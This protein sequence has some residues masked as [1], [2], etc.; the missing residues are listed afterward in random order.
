MGKKNIEKSLP[1]GK[2]DVGHGRSI[3]V[4]TVKEVIDE[5]WMGSV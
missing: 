5:P 1:E 2:N 4:C 3:M